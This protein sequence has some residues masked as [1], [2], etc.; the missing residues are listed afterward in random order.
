MDTERR[1]GFDRRK[2]TGI[3][4]RTFIGN[5]NKTTIRRQEDRDRIF[6]V[7]QYSPVLFAVIVVILFLCVI[8]ALLTL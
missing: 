2:Q 4:M 3:N 1:T 8:D 7:D 5:G 6:L